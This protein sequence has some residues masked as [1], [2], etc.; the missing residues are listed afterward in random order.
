MHIQSLSIR[1][2]IMIT[3]QIDKL[4]PLQTYNRGGNQI[5]ISFYLAKN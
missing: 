1:L 3:P 4:I 2:Q 5:S